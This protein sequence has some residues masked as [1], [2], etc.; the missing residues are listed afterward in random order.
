MAAAVAAGGASSG[1]G[2]PMPPPPVGG[3]DGRRR[4]PG[5]RDGRD[6]QDEAARV[7]QAIGRTRGAAAAAGSR[8]GIGGLRRC[9]LRRRGDDRCGYHRRGDGRSRD[10]RTP[11]WRPPPTTPGRH[12]RT[13]RHRRLTEDRGR[14]RRRRG[15]K[16]P[17]AAPAAIPAARVVADTR[18]S[19]GTAP[20]RSGR[21]RSVAAFRPS[22]GRTPL[23]I[24]L[25]VVALALVVGGAAAYPLPPDGDGRDRAS[26]GDHRP[27]VA[28][29][30]GQ[31][32]PPRRPMR[33]PRPR[34][35]RPSCSR[36]MSRPA[37]PSRPPASGS[38][39]PRRPEAC[40]STT[41][42]QPAR[43]S[44]PRGSVV[45]TGLGHPVPHRSGGDGPAAE[46]VGLTIVPSPRSVSGHGGRRRP[47]GECAS[48]TAIT[49]VPRGEEPFFLKVTNPEAT[50]GG[51]RTEFPRVQQEDVDKA[52]RP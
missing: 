19:K 11:G 36:S 17:V 14:P 44:I 46:L 16:R 42:T 48:R 51:K 18:P 32:R 13:R 20:T 24:G 23:V 21:S 34:S 7:G 1:A 28:A 31:R 37:T 47:G 12:R 45:S 35:C 8:G 27:R 6:A 22:I 49:T 41:S 10:R 38:R 29:D 33:R 25:A 40:G 30:R 4:D 3:E 43:T 2:P 5:Q 9:G 26:R 39:R 50:T 52:T 15:E